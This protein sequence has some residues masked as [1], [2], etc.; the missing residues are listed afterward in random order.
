[1]T[2]PDLAG[3]FVSSRMSLRVRV[4][5]L[6]LAFAVVPLLAIGAFDYVRSMHALEMLAENQ[7]GVLA[8]HIADEVADRFGTIQANLALVAENE[9][10][11]SLLRRPNGAAGAAAAPRE[12]SS[13]PDYFNQMW[14]AIGS[15]F[16]WI[17]IEDT[18]GLERYRL[19]QS[20]GSLS[21]YS[22]GS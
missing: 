13:A 5:L 9:D 18:S 10:T 17:A 8:R 6:F 11:K 15:D 14:S 22:D 2:L 12:A 21:I 1:M 3:P 7:T 20:A 4:I 16:D 19:G